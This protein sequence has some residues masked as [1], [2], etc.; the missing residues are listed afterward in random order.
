MLTSMACPVP[1]SEAEVFT[2]PLTVTV[3]VR[4]LRAVGVNVTL[5]EQLAPATSDEPQVLVCAKSPEATMPEIE[6]ATSPVLE[7]VMV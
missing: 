6:T 2:L 3:P 1:V 5:I 4:T 7:Y